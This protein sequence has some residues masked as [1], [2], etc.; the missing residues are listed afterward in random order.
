M[1]ME[2]LFLFFTKK[3]KIEMEFHLVKMVTPVLEHVSTL[4]AI[5]LHMTYKTH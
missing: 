3:Q 1:K 5:H 4:L 2:L